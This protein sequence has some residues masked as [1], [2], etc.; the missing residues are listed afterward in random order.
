MRMEASSPRAPP[1]LHQHHTPALLRGPSLAVA[2]GLTL[3]VS[4]WRWMCALG[5]NLGSW[6]F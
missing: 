2:Q 4:Q 5:L 6:A 3:V 1:D